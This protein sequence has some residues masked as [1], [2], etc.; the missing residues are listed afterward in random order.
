VFS[1]ADPCPRFVFVPGAL[2]ASPS[3]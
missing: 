2:R 1:V 3:T